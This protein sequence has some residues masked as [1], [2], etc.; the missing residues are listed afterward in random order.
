MQLNIVKKLEVIKSFFTLCLAS[1]LPT[2]RDR[3]EKYK[4]SLTKL[5][6]FISAG[7]LFMI[8]SFGTVFAQTPNVPVPS[9][10]LL[11]IF[12]E[13]PNTRYLLNLSGKL[14]PDKGKL[15]GGVP[16]SSIVVYEVSTDAR[17]AAEH[18]RSDPNVKIVLP[19]PKVYAQKTTNDPFFTDQWTLEATNVGG[20]SQTAWD[21]VPDLNATSGIKVAVIDTG[22]DRTHPDLAGKIAD[23]DWV[24]CDYNHTPQCYED[25]NGIDDNGHGTHI[26]GL[27]GATPDNTI[28]IAG[29]GWGTK[30]LSIKAL[31]ADGSG[32]LMDVFLAAAYALDHGVKVINLSLGATESSLGPDGIAATQLAIDDIWNQGG[33]MIVAA[34]NCG[35]GSD[36]GCGGVNPR[37]YPG[38]SN[39]VLSVGAVTTTGSSASYSERGNWVTVVAPGGSCL[40]TSEQSNCILSTWSASGATCPVSASPSG[41]CYEQGTS[42]ASPQVAGIAALM[43]AKNPNLTN[44]QILQI[45]EST[46]IP[47]IAQGASQFGMVDAKAALTSVEI[48]QNSPTPLPS[49]TSFPTPTDFFAS[50]TVVPTTTGLVCTHSCPLHEKGDA[51]CDGVINASDSDTWYRQFGTVVPANTVPSG[52]FE[53]TEGDSTSTTIDLID[54]EVWRR[55]TVQYVP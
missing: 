49:L 38:A 13:K 27:L 9:Q 17:T 8:F 32:S 31:K 5:S 21:L 2:E 35:N 12:K 16:N 55:N 14:A 10:D 29:V 18:V 36:P 6:L 45:I 3:K 25:S 23:S 30:I 43:L 50:P 1:P 37:M 47:S 40:S 46:S 11:I 48:P 33:L 54:F 39:H 51:N 4:F 7:S 26:A 44:A 15:K 19:M 42:M 20:S 34:G 53:C 52:N 24:T 41:Y 28:G 22:I